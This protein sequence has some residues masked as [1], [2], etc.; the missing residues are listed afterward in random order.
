MTSSN[1]WKVYKHTAPNGKVYIGVTHQ[2]PE[3]RW[4]A[5]KGYRSN[6]HFYNA[7]CKYGWG[8]F[9][10]E[11]LA[12]GLTE[13]DAIKMETELIAKYDSANKQYGYNV[14]LG[15]HNQSEE[16]RKKIG[17]TRKERGIIPPN[18][19]K[20]WSEETRKKIS[21]SLTGRRYH[22]SNAA[23]ENIRQAKIGEKNPNYGKPLTWTNEARF[24]KV[25]R[26]VVQIKGDQV[27][28]YDSAVIAGKETGITSG[29][30]CRA[31]QGK[32]KTA[33]GYEWRYA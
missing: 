12:E 10:H 33:G 5:G 26:A 31:C 3:N 16:S 14:A 9:E 30:I 7:I 29:N 32:R 27:V 18:K 17:A 11:V 23:R 15:G 13:E 6:T 2:K 20:K 24:A 28:R 22:V 21:E 8:N 19:G 1:V 25:Q 4:N